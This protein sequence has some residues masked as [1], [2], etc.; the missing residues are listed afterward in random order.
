[1]FTVVGSG[2]GLYG[3]VPALLHAFG[4]PVI[5]PAAYRERLEARG[6]L[7]GYASS[8]RWVADA[9]AALAQATG[10]VLATVPAEQPGWVARCCEATNIER[11]V[12]EKP[13]AVDPSAAQAVLDRL[14]RS[15]KR[16]RVG[17][18]LLHAAWNE[19]LRWPAAGRVAIDWTFMA[20][21]FAKGLDNWK[22]REA[23]GGGVV[24]F[25]G[26]HLFALLARHGYADVGG[27][28]VEGSQAGQP[29]RWH[30][31][32]TGPRLPPVEVRVDSRT[33]AE[34]FSIAF[35]GGARP[36]VDLREPFELERPSAPD[37]R[38]VPVL[39]RLLETFSQD[40]AAYRSLYAQANALWQRMEEA[41]AR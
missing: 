32:F 28:R 31:T 30:A 12:V 22:R 8:I 3:Y 1:M 4:E 18:T 39:E 40:D 27:S 15:G 13:L 24:R 23:E 19:G 10:V 33:A 17:Y 2:F 37:D 11:I 34:R 7:R 38:R 6:D 29:E 9:P 25:F 35:A 5:L 41:H 20:H 26:V 14:Q 16:Y 21:H 36:A